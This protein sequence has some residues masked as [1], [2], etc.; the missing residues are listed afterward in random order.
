LLFLIVFLYAF[1]LLFLIKF[2]HKEIWWVIGILL[3]CSVL[4]TVISLSTPNFGT[5]IRYK[6]A[7][8]PF[9]WFLAL[10]LMGKR[11]GQGKI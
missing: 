3:Y 8:M 11:L 10:W 7:Y 9:L 4:A 2:T 6:V 1:R 5:L